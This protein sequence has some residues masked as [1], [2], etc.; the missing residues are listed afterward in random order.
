[1]EKKYIYQYDNSLKIIFKVLNGKLTLD[2][3][4]D[5]WNYAKDNDIIPQDCIGFIS[6]FRDSQFDFNIKEYHKII[7]YFRANTG[8]FNRRKLAAISQRPRDVVIPT[9]IE[10]KDEGYF[11]KPFYTMEAAI[12]WV[13]K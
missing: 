6:D 2:D 3:I 13:R 10:S 11:C 8:L 1:M 7:D 4:F 9:I 12:D 5:S